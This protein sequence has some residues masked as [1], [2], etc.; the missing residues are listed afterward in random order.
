MADTRTDIA[1]PEAVW[2]DLYAATGIAVGTAV[3]VINKGS[4]ACYIAIKA[5]APTNGVGFPLHVGPVGSFA[6]IDASESGLWAYVPQGT[7]SLLVQE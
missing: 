2:T 5:T 4:S 7:T 6:S 3:D 1:V